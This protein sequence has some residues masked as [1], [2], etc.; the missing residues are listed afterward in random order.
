MTGGKKQGGKEKLVATEQNQSE[1][2]GLDQRAQ[3]A[4]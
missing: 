1:I 4:V 2:N 3:H